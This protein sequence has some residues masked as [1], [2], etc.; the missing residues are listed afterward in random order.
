MKSKNFNYMKR[1]AAIF[2]SAV[3]LVLSACSSDTVQE[4]DNTAEK[5]TEEVATKLQDYTWELPTQESLTQPTSETQLSET[6]TSAVTEVTGT[7]GATETEIVPQKPSQDSSDTSVNLYKTLKAELQAEIDKRD[8]SD[9]ARRYLMLSFDSLYQYYDV[10]ADLRFGMPSKEEYVRTNLISVI[11]DITKLDFIDI[12]SQKGQDWLDDGHALGETTSSFKVTIVYSEE[13]GNNDDIICLLHEIR[14]VKQKKIVFNKEYFKG[15]EYLKQFLIEGDASDKSYYA[16]NTCAYRRRFHGHLSGNRTLRYA[17]F[18]PYGY[19]WHYTIYNDLLYLVGFDTMERVCNGESP[20][21]IK[22]T[23]AR[24]YGEQSA[25]NIFKALKNMGSS[26]KGYVIFNNG[27]DFQ[28][29]FLKCVERDIANLKTKS[30]VIS[31]TNRYRFLKMNS[32]AELVENEK[33]RTNEFFDIYA[34]DEKLTQKIIS[35]KA[36]SF[37]NN[38]EE[39]HAAIRCLLFTTDEDFLGYE[40]AHKHIQVPVNL[41]EADYEYKDKKLFLNYIDRDPGLEGREVTLEMSFSGGKVV[42][43]ETDEVCRNLKPLM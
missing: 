20:A 1:I 9:V 31:F 24:K 15:Y 3:I 35:T 38:A 39:N 33:V 40:D 25:D 22:E 5:A 19:P 8:F 12:E 43:K 27:V 14:H 28:K 32:L 18:S 29:E 36:F 16:M 2:L 34:L 30:E 4:K 21:I 6:Q 13:N 11:K 41:K 17:S 10:W 23:I 42:A 37:S 26:E 7:S